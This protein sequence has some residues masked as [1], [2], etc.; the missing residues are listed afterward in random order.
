MTLSDTKQPKG[1]PLSTGASARP[2]VFVDGAAGTTGLG[3]REWLSQQNDVVQ[4]TTSVQAHDTDAGWDVR[5]EFALNA[6]Q[7]QGHAQ[8]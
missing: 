6:V 7:D 5:D 4:R 8:P 2:T 1:Q 3:I